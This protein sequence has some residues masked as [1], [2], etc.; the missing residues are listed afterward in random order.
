VTAAF[1]AL[2]EDGVYH[3]PTIVQKILDARGG[4]VWEHAP[5][6][7]RLV[8]SSTAKS[9]MRMLE[10]V[11]H[12]DLGTGNNA[13]VD[14]YRVAG[15]TSTA[16][17]AGSK[18]YAEGMYYSSFIGA[19]PA[20]SPRVVIL[21]S[22]DAPEGA[23]YGNDV[24]APSFARLGGQ[25]MTHLGVPRDDGKTPPAPKPVVVAAKEIAA[26]LGVLADID[27]EPSLPGTTR[28]SGAAAHPLVK[29]GLPDFTGLTLA[30]AVD[31]AGRSHVEL[32]AVGSGVAV[33]Q[34]VPPGQVESGRVVQVTFEPP[35]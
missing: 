2:A 24:A 25:I 28:G 11:V 29:T 3:D 18:G 5:E 19:L 10:D 32:R 34:D 33:A 17:K 4:T 30:Q 12:T 26:E 23:H 21:V 8:R 15:K 9:V 13:L 35:K 16:Q 27:V 20:R 7:E 31:L 14:G 1:A 6:G 22:V